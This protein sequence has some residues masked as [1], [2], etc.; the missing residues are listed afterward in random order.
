MGVLNVTPDSFSDGGE[1]AVVNA[2]VEQAEL[3]IGAGAS[4]IDVGGESTRPNATAVSIEEELSRVIPVIEGI[5][6]ASDVQI[7]IDTSKPEVMKFAISAGANIINDV[8]ALRQPGSLEMAASLGVP[9]CLMHMQ[10]KPETMQDKPCYANVVEEVNDFFIQRIKACEAVGI[11][12]ENIILDPGFGFGKTLQH[13]LSLLAHLDSFNSHGCPILAGLSRKSMLG[14]ILNKSVDQRVI[15]SVLAA[16]MAVM[17]G[18][19]IVRVH[20]VAQ[21]SDALKIYNAVQSA[22]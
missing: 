4:I 22:N 8:Y 2:A 17:N 18:A 21:T 11:A 5:R 16:L 19:S 14:E 1:F 13:N 10:D 6:S 7:S 15:G 9:V 20:D 12:K 3:M